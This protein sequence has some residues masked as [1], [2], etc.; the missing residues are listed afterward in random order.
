MIRI[1][2][3]PNVFCLD[4]DMTYIAYDSLVHTILLN[5]NISN[6]ILI[7]IIITRNILNKILTN[8]FPIF[9]LS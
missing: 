5:D 8:K 9:V 7:I 3:D 2:S 4:P 6:L 1:R